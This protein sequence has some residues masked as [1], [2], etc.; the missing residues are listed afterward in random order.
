MDDF[1]PVWSQPHPFVLLDERQRDVFTFG[2]VMTEV[3]SLGHPDGVRAFGRRWGFEWL[4]GLS[5]G[6]QREIRRKLPPSELERFLL[7]QH[8]FLGP[9]HY[10]LDRWAAWDETAGE[11]GDEIIRDFALRHGAQIRRWAG[12]AFNMLETK[13]Y[14]WARDRER[15]ELGHGD[16]VRRRLKLTEMTHELT[17]VNAMDG[18][19][20]WARE[21]TTLYERAALEFEDLAVRRPR[22][23]ICPLCIRVYLPVRPGQ[24][25]CGNQL[26][27]ATSR[28]LVRRCT[29][30]SEAAVYGAAEAAEYRKRRKT[31]WAAMNRARKSYGHNDS[32][33]EHAIEEWEAWR[34]ENPP[35]RPPGRP[36]RIAPERAEPP[37]S[38]TGD[39]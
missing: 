2:L 11:P 20:H 7:E 15:V 3:R 17:S 31:R 28:Q 22:P 16:A 24:P 23:R 37:F 5:A 25:I 33:T 38:P 39:D 13:L 35:P 19:H 32:R 8:A 21:Y 1:L 9:R 4:P 18:S 30:L 14:T 29:P 6:V 36:R 34:N 12:N 26:W 10:D 27:D